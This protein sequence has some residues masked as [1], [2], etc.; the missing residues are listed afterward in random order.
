MAE[1]LED[2]GVRR[3]AV[4]PPARRPLPRSHPL[5]SA[6]GARDPDGHGLRGGPAPLGRVPRA[7]A[8]LR[9]LE[10][11]V[12]RGQHQH[13]G[14]PAP[15]ARAAPQGLRAPEHHGERAAGGRGGGGVVYAPRGARASSSVA[16]GAGE[17]KAD[18]SSAGTA[19]RA[20]SRFVSSEQLSSRGRLIKVTSFQS[21]NIA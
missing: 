14:V 4:R 16:E 15:E 10:E 19:P 17:Q 20:G 1:T 6:L 18:R 3:G 7:R 11:G 2:P 9:R 5:C 21:S 8:A 12:E 13:R